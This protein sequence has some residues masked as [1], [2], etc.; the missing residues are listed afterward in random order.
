MYF[1]VDFYHKSR[2]QF[3]PNNCQLF[4]R[5]VKFSFLF[6]VNYPYP[7]SFLEPLPAWP[8]KVYFTARVQYCSLLTLICKN[9]DSKLIAVS[10][11]NKWRHFKDTNLIS[12]GMQSNAS[13]RC[14]PLVALRPFVPNYKYQLLTHFRHLPTR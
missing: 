7:A 1:L 3:Y 9:T 13:L 8:I 11:Y 10:L 14:R 5:D 4:V 6:L 2:E 12:G